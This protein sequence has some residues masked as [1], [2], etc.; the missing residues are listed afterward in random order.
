M[1]R[2]EFKVDN[3]FSG[4]KQS[5]QLESTQEELSQAQT[6][7]HKLTEEIEK[8]RN[9]QTHAETLEKSIVNL[10]TELEKQSGKQLVPIELIKPNPEQPRKTILPESIEAM[11]ISLAKEGQLSPI[12][13]IESVENDYLIFDG[14]RRWRGGK[15]NQ[16][17]H[18][19]SVIIKKPQDLHRKALLTSLHRED[20]NS[21]DKAEAI[22]LEIASKTST[23][24]QDIP[25]ILSRTIRRFNKK[26][27]I[28][29]ITELLSSDY[30]Q[31]EIGLEKLELKAEE[32][33]ILLVLLDLQLNPASIDANIFPMLSLSKDLKQ[34]IR[35]KGLNG[36]QA[37]AL[38]TL[39]PKNLGLSSQESNK[40]RKKTT[41]QVLK[42]NLSASQ[43]RKL[44][45]EIRDKYQQVPKFNRTIKTV[46]SQIQ[47][48]TPETLTETESEQLKQLKS[49][50]ESKLAEI[51]EILLPL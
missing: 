38:Q 45:K 18:I 11:A 7:I 31:C 6:K 25:R 30:H 46:V 48:L 16:W 43:T 47:K 33:A 37:M 28:S 27:E 15:K 10:R 23:Q 21:L 2:Q 12:I 32:K 49:L 35:E 14:E 44:V 17:Q 1:T 26:K 3:W 29:L 19:E 9:T 24:E 51:E 39:N 13:L 5:Q 34:A 8:L 22:L 36:S 50:L 4:A 41:Q 40:I 42:D 20:L